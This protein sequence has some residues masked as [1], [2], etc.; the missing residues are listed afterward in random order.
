MAKARKAERRG[1]LNGRV[2]EED[3][4]AERVLAVTSAIVTTSS[5]EANQSLQQQQQLQLKTASLP[6]SGESL[7]L[8]LPPI[9]MK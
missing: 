3:E 2:E 6:H 8:S 9:A 4:G 7:S 5:M 1:A